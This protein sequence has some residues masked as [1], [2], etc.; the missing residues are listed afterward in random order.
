MHQL[1]NDCPPL[2]LAT[3]N[4]WPD[5]PTFQPWPRGRTPLSPAGGRRRLRRTSLRGHNSVR[6][7]GSRVSVLTQPPF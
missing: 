4:D 7:T 1:A 2:D 5:L 3:A 6:A